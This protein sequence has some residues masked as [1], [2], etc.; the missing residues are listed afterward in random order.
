MI[1][2]GDLRGRDIKRLAKAMGEPAFRQFI[3]NARIVSGLHHLGAVSTKADA[4]GLQRLLSAM[5]SGQQAVTVIAQTGGA[6]EINEGVVRALQLSGARVIAL[7]QPDPNRPGNI[8]VRASGSVVATGAQ[9]FPIDPVTRQAQQ[10]IEQMDSAIRTLEATPTYRPGEVSRT[11]A[12]S[13]I[14]GEVRRLEGLIKERMELATGDLHR[15]SRSAANEQQLQAVTRDLETVSGMEQRLTSEEVLRLARNAPQAGELER[16]LRVARTRGEAS[17]RFL[18]LI[19]QVDPRTAREIMVSEIGRLDRSHQRRAWRRIRARLEAQVETQQAL[20]MHSG[21]T[22]SGRAFAWFGLF[23]EAW[24]IAEPFIT[25]AFRESQDQS[26]EDVYRF[27]RDLVW[28][29]EKGL[30]PIAVGVASDQEIRD[31]AAISASLEHRLHEDVPEKQRGRLTI[32]PE[33]KRAS[34]LQKLYIPPLGD[35]PEERRREFWTTFML[36]TS[37]HIQNF[38]DYASEFLEGMTQAPVR[39]APN[40]NGAFG[41]QRWQ[42]RVGVIDD[43]GHVAERWQDSED[44]TR[45]MNT[46]AQRVMRTTREQRE[47]RWTERHEPVETQEIMSDPGSQQ[48]RAAGDQPTMHARFTSGVKPVYGLMNDSTYRLDRFRFLNEEPYFMVIGNRNQ[49]ALRDYV[50]VEGADYNTH[51]AIRSATVWNY[52]AKVRIPRRPEIRDVNSP[53]FMRRLEP[54]EYMNH[55]ELEAWRLYTSNPRPNGVFFSE[56]AESESR[57]YRG[58]VTL[59]EKGPNYRAAVLLRRE[60]LKPE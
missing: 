24:K 56:F 48:P 2:V 36:W 33:A 38:D 52:V 17:R 18:E 59:Y 8:T 26:R 60:D 41:N 30:A 43:S 28:W 51:A 42:L 11:E 25:Q 20:A 46:T 19:A 57:V 15:Q 54:E 31:P 35:W 1:T 5:G 45:I 12:I 47:E 27:F 53:D 10:R 39:Q 21:P 3:G 6:S 7:G 49:G 34:S 14:R 50:W 9:D 13:G 4:R 23:L 40:D 37:A 16:E 58:E 44:L 32:S 55:E 29:G 22:R